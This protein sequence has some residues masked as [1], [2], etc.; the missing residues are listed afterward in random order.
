MR[1]A[2]NNTISTAYE[3]A[4]DE[5]AVLLKGGSLR[6]PRELESAKVSVARKYSLGRIPTNSEIL[7]KLEPEKREVF[8]RILRV[9]STRSASGVVVVAV[10]TEPAPCPHGRCIYCPG[11]PADGT[12]QSYTG[13][14][15]AAMRGSQY[16]YDPY[17]QAKARLE[18][19]RNT[20]H[21][22]HKVEVIVMG[23]T[24]TSR[25]LEYQKHLVKRIL[26]AL[27]GVDARDLEE[28]KR[29]AEKA[30]VR[31]VGLTVETRPDYCK[32]ENVD[33]M[34]DYATTRVEIGVQTI[35]P[36]VLEVVGRGHDIED[37][38]EAIRVAKDSGLKVGVHMMPGLPGSSYEQDLE[39]F[40]T[41]FQD[42]RYVPDMLKIYPTLVLKGTKLFDMW[43]MGEYKPMDESTAVN[44]VAEVLAMTPKWV[45]VM[46]V[47]RDIPSNL[48]QAGPKKG[49]LRELALQKLR[50]EGRACQEIR[51]R[52]AG[53]L[54]L[55]QGLKS[56]DITLRKYEY[57][58]SG[59]KEHFLCWESGDGEVLFGYMRMRIPSKRAH[60]Q[61]I[62]AYRCAIVRELKVLGLPA[63]FGKRAWG[64]YQHM[65][66]G[67]SLMQ[68]AESVAIELGLEK[69][70]VTSA[71]GVREY[72][73]RLGYQP[74]GPYVSKLLK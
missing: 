8:S 62:A 68:E 67:R 58:S 69:I 27:N 73:Y 6:T 3:S 54:A 47:Q 26:D 60:R 37:T 56:R 36:E 44:L 4:L 45:R 63:P 52:E 30:E 41:L 2:L 10:M 42:E 50:S 66:F 64:S 9:K 51:C 17:L 15:P 21:P 35:F 59:G 40:K 70:L 20:G 61:E 24:F 1:T 71:V 29:I 49:N 53:L 25:P 23:G 31:N 5:I 22:T 19:L 18:Q 13:H 65:G 57:V 38:I 34:L 55:R 11:G 74:E 72:Y 33:A 7:S 32:S 28:A 16:G 39:S 46:R 14:E 43:K 12:P 48:I